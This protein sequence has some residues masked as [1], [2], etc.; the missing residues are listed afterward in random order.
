MASSSSSSSA[1]AGGGEGRPIPLVIAKGSDE[2]SGGGGGE[3]GMFVVGE[4]AMAALRKFE[5]PIAVVAIVGLYR[6]GK[7]YLVNRIVGQQH[8]FTVGPT[9]NACTKGIWMWSE[10]I[11]FENSRGEK[12]QLLVLDT[13]GIGG[14]KSSS[15]YDTRIFSLAVLLC[16]TLIYNSLGSI[17]ETAVSNLS[18]VANLSQHVQVKANQGADGD[19]SGGDGDGDSAATAAD[20]LASFFPSFMW[21]I[22]DFAL[23][24]VD[25]DYNDISEQDYLENCLKQKDGFS[26]DVL[27]KNRIRKS[28]T[29]FFRQRDCA[30]IV[31]PIDDEAK[32]HQIDE[33]P[34]E[35][36]RPAF[37]TQME[38]MRKR[39]LAQLTAKSL[40]GKAMS[41]SMFATLVRTYVGA[42]NTDG[43]PTITTAWDHVATTET[44]VAMKRSLASFR[45]ALDEATGGGPG[46]AKLPLD[47]AVLQASHKEMK[48]KAKADFV[49]GAVGADAEDTFM[50][51]LKKSMQDLFAD[52]TVANESASS[53][54]CGDLFDAMHK[55]HVA[56]RLPDAAGGASG[57][58][59]GDVLGDMDAVR[60][61]FSRLQDAYLEKARGPA[62]NKVLNDRLVAKHAE[63]NAVVTS[64][65]QQQQDA[66]MRRV[67]SRAHEAEAKLAQVEGKEQVLREE[68]T[69][70]REEQGKG[71]A[72]ASMLAIKLS[73]Q[74][75]EVAMLRKR[76]EDAE[77]KLKADA[78]KADKERSAHEMKMERELEQIKLE[79]KE[80][81]EALLMAGKGGCGCVIA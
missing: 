29:N 35:A 6:T 44:K 20:A 24:L 64:Y 28:L 25:E 14:T 15:E 31:R 5:G 58:G 71:E 19:G 50:A 74:E 79:L 46:F 39:V 9:V 62:R 33:Q 69:S 41:G 68:L 43:V 38:G 72:S 16:S 78:S 10:P 53:R 36:L 42:M 45:A 32:L 75:Q 37:R 26:S 52:V 3:E 67:L 11:P 76:A 70:V 60:R 66:E 30:T 54:F 2:D 12:M 48:R 8:G 81:D 73:G 7:S 77:A 63:A 51:K 55:E 22:R 18:F 47:E 65:M 4:D 56:S 49:A 40:R 17:D 1:S 21:V 23:E 61:A 27:E 13:E 34:Y 59:G 80:K 57:G